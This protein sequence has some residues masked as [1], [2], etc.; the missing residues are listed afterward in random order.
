MDALDLIS[1]PV[2]EFVKLFTAH[3]FHHD[4]VAQPGISQISA[5]RPHLAGFEQFQSSYTAPELLQAAFVAIGGFF[6]ADQFPV[7]IH[8]STCRQQ[9]N[10]DY[11]EIVRSSR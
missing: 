7:G 10:G 8:R 2:V 1:D 6:V 5:E 4:P 3:R 9:R 11:V